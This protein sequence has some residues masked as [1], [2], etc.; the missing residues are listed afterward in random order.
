MFIVQSPSAEPELLRAKIEEFLKSFQKTIK[1]LTKKEFQ[2]FV[3]SLK[4]IYDLKPDNFNAMGQFYYS[5]IKNKDYNL[6]LKKELKHALTKVTLKDFMQFYEE[7][8]LNEATTRKILVQTVGA[9][10][11]NNKPVQNFTPIEDRKKFKKNATF[12]P[13]IKEEIFLF[14]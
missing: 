8:F 1:K 4:E 6:Q 7:L 12:S 14:P 9:N 3:R 13:I 2:T 10:I 11:K 5:A